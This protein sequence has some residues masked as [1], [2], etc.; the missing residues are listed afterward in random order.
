MMDLECDIPMFQRMPHFNG[1]YGAIPIAITRMLFR[2]PS[3]Y[4]IKDHQTLFLN[5]RPIVM[6]GDRSTIKHLL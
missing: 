6:G 3:F 4:Q 5:V 2:G 1:M